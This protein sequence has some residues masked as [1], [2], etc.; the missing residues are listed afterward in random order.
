MAATQAR[1]VINYAVHNQFIY[2]YGRVK[3]MLAKITRKIGLDWRISAYR[4]YWFYFITCRN[5]MDLIRYDR[6]RRHFSAIILRD[7]SVIQFQDIEQA[8]QIFQEIWFKRNYTRHYAQS[9]PSVIVDIGANIGIFSAL[10]KK[11]WTASIIYA[12]EP[13]EKN[14]SFLQSNILAPEKNNDRYHTYLKA[15]SSECGE[16]VFYIKNHSG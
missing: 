7:G 12:Y 8:V 10:A 15:V 1:A 13:E 2:Y 16:M 4:R 6:M 14:F 11:L 3:S 5:Y 9:A